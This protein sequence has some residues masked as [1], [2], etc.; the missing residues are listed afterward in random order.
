[1]Q[2]NFKSD[3]LIPKTKLAFTKLREVFIKALILHHFNLKRHIDI[4]TDDF[5]YAIDRVFN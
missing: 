3:F 4:K 2:K 5:G 1:M